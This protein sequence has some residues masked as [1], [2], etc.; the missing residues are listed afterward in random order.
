V[1]TV[2]KCETEP[3]LFSASFT[4]WPMSWFLSFFLDLPLVLTPVSFAGHQN[5]LLAAFMSFSYSATPSPSPL[6]A[7]HARGRCEKRQVP[8]K[9][10]PALA[11]LLLPLFFP[12]FAVVVVVLSRR[13]SWG[14]GWAWHSTRIITD[15]I[16]DISRGMNVLW[17]VFYFISLSYNPPANGTRC[18]FLP[19]GWAGG[20]CVY[21]CMY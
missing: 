10:L 5:F 20:G 12:H 14:W 19:R 16:S 7:A 6:P 21:V 15:Q 11:S 8:K 9:M 18:P 2:E 3:L 17:C 1:S 13:A 4:F